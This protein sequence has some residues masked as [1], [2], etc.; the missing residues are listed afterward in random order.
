MGNYKCKYC[1]LEN[2]LGNEYGEYGV[3]ADR[4][5]VF[6]ATYYDDSGKGIPKGR[7]RKYYHPGTTTGNDFCRSEIC[8]KPFGEYKVGKMPKN[9][10]LSA[11][12]YKDLINKIAG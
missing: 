4:Y 11:K 2:D 7:I 8:C 1:G 6:E 3:M 9:C 12:D 10:N 5:W